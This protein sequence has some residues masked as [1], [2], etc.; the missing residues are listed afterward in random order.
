MKPF[1]NSALYLAWVVALSG[2]LVSLYYGEVLDMEPCRLC[3][4]QRIGLFPLALFL[5]IATYKNDREIALYSLPL[6]GF[7]GLFA[8]YQSMTQIL[9]SL[10]VAALCGH[11][12]HC[13][14]P[15][16]LP[17]LS[18][19]GF[20]GMAFLIFLAKNGPKQ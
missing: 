4:Y 9:P 3:W 5:G 2:L 11:T 15:G 18:A 19:S 12:A 13:T 17:I 16:P 10:Q 14:L 20:A 6:I 7:G 8:L 1:R